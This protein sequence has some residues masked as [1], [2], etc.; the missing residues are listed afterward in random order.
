MSFIN[1]TIKNKLHLLIVCVTVLMN[2]SICSADAPPVTLDKST[3]IKVSTS[4][5]HGHF[6]ETSIDF[7]VL[8]SEQYDQYIN[9]QKDNKN[10]SKLSPA[11]ESPSFY[12]ITKPGTYFVGFDYYIDPDYMDPEKNYPLFNSRF[13][14]DEPERFEYTMGLVFPKGTGPRIGYI[15]RKW[16]RVDIEKNGVYKVVATFIKK[17]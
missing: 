6:K 13:Y 12:K 4:G 15:I 9:N 16:Y 1:H 7:Y 14:D 8:N 2:V 17:L 5:D 10:K 3:G 11:S